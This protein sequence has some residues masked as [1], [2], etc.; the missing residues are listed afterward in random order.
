MNTFLLIV[1]L[2][3]SGNTRAETGAK[4]VSYA[5]SGDCVRAAQAQQVGVGLGSPLAMCIASQ[6][7]TVIYMHV[8]Q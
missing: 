5:T 6:D 3:A 8:E 1:V 4:V 7:G 2:L